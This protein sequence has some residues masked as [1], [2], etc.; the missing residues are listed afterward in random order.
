MSAGRSWVP[1][2]SGSDVRGAANHPPLIFI[3][4][5]QEHSRNERRF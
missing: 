4:L 2:A 1:P 5:A 3:K